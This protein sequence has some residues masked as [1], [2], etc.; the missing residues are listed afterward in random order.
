MKR[1][2]IVHKYFSDVPELQRE[3]QTFGSLSG[4]GAEQHFS[5]REA[6]MSKDG[7][8]FTLSC[9]NCGSRNAITVEWAELVIVG[10][11]VVPPNWKYENGRLFPNVGCRS[12]NYIS[13]ITL[14]PDEA[15]KN[16]NAAINARV[17][18]AQFVQQVRAQ[19][20]RR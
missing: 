11:G 16:V 8:E 15:A 20:G 12:C 4:F 3:E 18:N 2:T 10:S 9:D 14:T 1:R 19:L 6:G 7:K 13:S 17:L 5:A